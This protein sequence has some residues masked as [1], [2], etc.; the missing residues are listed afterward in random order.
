MKRLLMVLFAPFTLVGGALVGYYAYAIR[1]A[2]DFHYLS[3]HNDYPYLFAGV[4]LVLLGVLVRHRLTKSMFNRITELEGKARAAIDAKDEALVE[5]GQLRIK[6]A[7][8]DNVITKA[9]HTQTPEE[10]NLL[11]EEPLE[12]PAPDYVKDKE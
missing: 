12:E 7:W 8:V 4:A 11:L 3:L 6:M 1:V 2:S 9:V 10:R 5:L